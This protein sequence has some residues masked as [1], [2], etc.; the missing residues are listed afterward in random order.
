MRETAQDMK[1]EFIEQAT[2]ERP[3]DALRRD[4]DVELATALLSARADDETLRRYED[5][6]DRHSEAG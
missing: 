6:A 4:R 2:Y 1:D 5:L 3:L